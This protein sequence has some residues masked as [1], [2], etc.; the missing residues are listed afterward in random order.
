MRRALRCSYLLRVSATIRQREAGRGIA[1]GGYLA[2]VRYGFWII[3]VLVVA[4]DQWT[5]YLVQA[6]L[7]LNGPS[8]PVIPGALWLTHVHNPG[9]A[10]GQFAGGGPLLIFTA[11]VAAVAIIV[12][13]QRLLARQGSLHPVLVFGLALPLGG[14][15]GNMIDRIR[16][17]V[18]VDFLDLGWWPVFNVADSAITVGAGCLIAYFLFIQRDG[19]ETPVEP[20]PRP[21]CGAE[22]S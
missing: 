1:R 18:V 16:L 17:G 20:A 10:F 11:A 12:Y 2:V 19:E 5:K 7:P 4:L 15:V 3:A 9:V 13:H 8:T 6:N 14:A 22:R 21:E